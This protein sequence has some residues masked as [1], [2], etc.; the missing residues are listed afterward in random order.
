MLQDFDLLIADFLLQ[1]S[2]HFAGDLSHQMRR[3]TQLVTALVDIEV[4]RL[5]GF[6]LDHDAVESGKLELGREKAASLT[7][8]D[9][10]AER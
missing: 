9:G 8:P 7:V 4:D 5:R 1:D 10:S 6:S 2:I 3:I